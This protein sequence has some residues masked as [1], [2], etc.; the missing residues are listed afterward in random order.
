MRF[1]AKTI[2]VGRWLL[3]VAAGA[4]TALAF[5]PFNISQMAWFSLVPLLFAVENCDWG[6]AFRRGYIAGLVFFG[7][8]VWWLVHVTVPGAVAVIAFLALYFGAAAVVFATACAR[9]A[10]T[11]AASDGE[12]GDTVIQNL[13]A[14][15]VGTAC[16]VTLEWVRGCFPLGGFPWNFLGVSQ[17][18]ATPLIQFANV[19]GVYG[20][21]ALLCFVNHAFYF[22]IRRLVRQMGRATVTRRL[23][24]EFYVAM[25][26]VCLALWHGIAE[27]RSGSGQP[28]RT[29]HLGLVQ[30]DIPQTLKFDPDERGLILGR[31]RQL[32]E[33]LLA[34]HLDLIIWPETAIPWAVQYDPESIELVTNILARSKAH[35]LTGFFDNR[36]P[37]MFNAAILFTPQPAISAIYRKIHLVPFGEYIPLRHVWSPLLRKIGPKDYDVD[38]FFDLS[39]GQEYTVFDVRGF[40]FGAVICYED[41]VPD[42]YRRF[43]QHDVDFMVNLTN[44]AWFKTSPEL[45]THLANAVFRAVEN[46]R[47]LVRATNNGVTC[48]VSEHGFIAARCAPF[49]D[50]SLSVALPLPT[51][52]AQTFYTRHGDLF[53]GAC[54]AIF[55]VAIGL[56]AFR[57]NRLQSVA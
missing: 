13:G 15:V 53:V 3:P 41:T 36:R 46:R 6:E 30:P 43:V 24:W 45:E 31:H 16:W 33:A 19:T 14:A 37:K 8:T 2:W 28:S 38:D 22:T 52:H 18:Q 40:R 54:A 47:P 26:L 48:V 42:L 11:N 50:N 55:A 51:D 29:L 12:H 1:A 35:L 20:V 44:D 56:A 7:M 27:I 32:T 57:R 23:H 34:D 21:S 5:P 4:A 39:A 17:W 25:L 10:K 49:R 9:I